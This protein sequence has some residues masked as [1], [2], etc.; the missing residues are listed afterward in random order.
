RTG[1]YLAC[2][3]IDLCCATCEMDAVALDYA[4]DVSEARKVFA[5][6]QDR[7]PLGIP[8][9]PERGGC[10]PRPRGNPIS[11]RVSLDVRHAGRDHHAFRVGKAPRHEPGDQVV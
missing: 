10:L 5:V 7:L 3:V 1:V 2:G 9:L 11:L 8:Q 6:E 4:V